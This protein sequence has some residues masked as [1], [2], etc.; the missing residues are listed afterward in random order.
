MHL[1]EKEALRIL[2][3][4]KTSEK[5]Y[6]S[7]LSHS[8]KVKKIALQISKELKGIDK[9]FLATAALLHDIGRFENPPGKEGIMHG[10]AGFNILRKEG[11]PRHA[12]AAER[13]VGSGITKDEAKKLGLPVRSYMP[14]TKEEK[15]LCYA[16]SLVFG[17]KLGTLQMVLKRYRKEVGK[18]LVKRTLKLNKVIEKMRKKS[19]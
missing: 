5:A 4:H 8:Q 2:R 14:R 18:A 12:R 16:D 10:V 15:I 6:R 3:R 19:F 13:H 1:T 17:S 9:N 7:I 11:L